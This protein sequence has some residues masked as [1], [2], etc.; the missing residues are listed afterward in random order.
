[1]VNISSFEGG[2]KGPEG[3]GCARRD[4]HTPLE[5]GTAEERDVVPGPQEETRSYLILS[6]E[7]LRGLLTPEL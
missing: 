2:G 5:A 1:M 7:D 4:D 6:W 3:K